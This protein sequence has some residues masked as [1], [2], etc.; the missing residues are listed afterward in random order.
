MAEEGKFFIAL[1]VAGGGFDDFY[2]YELELEEGFSKLYKA[3]LTVFSNTARSYTELT[4]ALDK[5]ASLAIS[6][7]LVDMSAGRLSGSGE[8]RTRYLHG[9]IT[10]VSAGG[11][12][13]NGDAECFAY[14]LVI[15]PE[16]ARLRFTCFSAPY[17]GRNP[18]DV[19][20]DILGKYGVRALFSS[21]Y[22]DRSVYG[23]NLMF[24][25]NKMSDYAF[26]DSMLALYG[27]SY[28]FV[29]SK[30]PKTGCGSAELYFSDGSQFP[31]PA[32]DYSD[33]RAMPAPAFDFIKADSESGA[34]KMDAWRMEKSIGVDG[35]RVSAPYSN[36]SYGSPD[37]CEGGVEAGD[38]Y[39]QYNRLFHGYA[40]AADKAEIDADVKRSI[41]ARYNSFQL[42]KER[43]TGKASTLA[44]MPGVQFELRH[45]LG[46]RDAEIITA[47]V[48]E[49]RLRVRSVWRTD[50]AA[51]PEGIET[52]EQLE[53]E[54]SAINWGAGSAFR[55][56]VPQTI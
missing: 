12:F 27:L 43:W 4:D 39:I 40:S 23:A 38:R 47:L 49:S 24:D 5:P 26:I 25:Q 19:I 53:I 7:R 20:A 32:L 51:K 45:F 9:I 8:R 13:Y 30:P 41:E 2:P 52:G 54:F 44:L 1:R 31:M 10:G 42:D 3:R 14:T 34:I 55:Y 56:T 36:A 46:K 29:H 11:I 48:T 37:W 35:V 22:I 28:V 21:D 18:L 33:S 17:Y 6:Q 15:E 16:L 50:L